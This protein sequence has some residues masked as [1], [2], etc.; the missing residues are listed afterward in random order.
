[1][2]V[3]GGHIHI[4]VDGVSIAYAT[5]HSL[6]VTLDTDDSSNKDEGGGDWAFAEGAILHWSG[7]SENIMSNDAKGKS[8]EDLL[9]AMITK[10]PVDLVFGQKADTKDTTPPE[11]G[12]TPATGKGRKGK[13]L[14]TSISANAPTEGKATYTVQ[15]TGVGPLEKITEA[16]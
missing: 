14:I 6:D 7:S 11:G 4:F 13:A 9:D 8:Y 3:K 1:M 10:E 5:S 2:K 16:V 15:F 12:W